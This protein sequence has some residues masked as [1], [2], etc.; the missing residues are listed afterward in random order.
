ML[1]CLTTQIVSRSSEHVS[2][3]SYA[4]EKTS[5]VSLYKLGEHLQQISEF[6]RTWFTHTLI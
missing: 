1:Q 2:L 6:V 3:H 5:A 4:S